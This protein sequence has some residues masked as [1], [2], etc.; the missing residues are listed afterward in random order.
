[1]LRKWLVVVAATAFLTGALIGCEPEETGGPK[2]TAVT[3]VKEDTADDAEKKE[4][5]EAPAEKKEGTEA[6]AKTE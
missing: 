1:M 6:P 4:G 2:G 5:T 3:P